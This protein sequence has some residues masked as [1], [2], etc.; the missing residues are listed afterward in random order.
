[1]VVPAAA[2]TL[3]WLLL[4]SLRTVPVMMTVP[5]M[6]VVAAPMIMAVAVTTTAVGS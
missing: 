5:V 4:L 2:A 3:L 6:A 1:M